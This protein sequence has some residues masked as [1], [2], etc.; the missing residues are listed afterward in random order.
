MSKTYFEHY[1]DDD[2]AVD[3]QLTLTSDGFA[4]LTDDIEGLIEKYTSQSA[5]GKCTEIRNDA[6]DLI[7]SIINKNN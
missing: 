7:H 2:G 4:S 1:V 3:D 5:F 6:I